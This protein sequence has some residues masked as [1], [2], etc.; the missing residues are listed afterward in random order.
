M[1]SSSFAYDSSNDENIVTNNNINL[2]TINNIIVSFLKQNPIFTNIQLDVEIIEI[3]QYKSMVFT[4]VTDTSA[5]ISAI[6]YKSCYRY[7]LKIG[8]KIKIIAKIDLYRGQ[9][10]LTIMK[11]DKI[12]SGDENKNLE[13]LI[14]KLTGLGYLANK[15]HIS[16]DYTKIGVITS[17]NAAGFRDFCYTLNNRCY[18]KKIF[19]YPATVQGK[20]AAPEIINAIELANNHNIVEVIVL[21]RGG[22][23][24]EDLECFNSEDLAHAIYKSSIPI[25]TGIGH[26]IDTSIADIVS[27]KSFI[28]P[29]AVAQNITI[30]NKNNINKMNTMLIN[31]KQHISTIVNQRYEYI[32]K[33]QN[34]IDKYYNLVY[35]DYQK[36]VSTNKSKIITIQQTIVTK[37]NMKYNYLINYSQQLDFLINKIIDGYHDMVVHHNNHSNTLEHQYENSIASY[38]DCLNKLCQVRIYNDSGHEIKLLEQVKN[39]RNI[40]IKFMDGEYNVKI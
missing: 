13:Q 22:G 18:H 21:I 1:S 6:I 15:P 9:L 27:A 2:I 7:P 24:R 23:S 12:G 5:S 32:T 33:C 34:K 31:I 11:Y 14:V 38:T 28:T 37:M 26:Q 20:N 36:N 25:V 29:T 19:V 16:D 17:P 8:D 39:S 10:Q 30:D 4:R 3:K 35:D 40:C